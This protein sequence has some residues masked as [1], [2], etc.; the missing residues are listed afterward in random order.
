MQLNQESAIERLAALGMEDMPVMEYKPKRCVI[1]KDWFKKYSRLRREFL[2]S[3]ADSYEEIA[4]MNLTQD[5]VMDL[6]MGKAAPANTSIRFRIP[7]VWGGELDIS[8]M[9]MCLTFPHCH[10]L[11]RFI[12]EQSDAGI[13]FLPDPA[14]KIYVSTHLGGG[15]AGGNA[16]SDRLSLAAMN[17]ASNRGNE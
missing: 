11:D 1:D 16:A 10:N 4:F 2:A 8:N 15:G 7:L 3:L 5:E 9:F 17:Y 6:L 12:L 14:K 13:V